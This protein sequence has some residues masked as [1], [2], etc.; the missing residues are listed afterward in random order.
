VLSGRVPFVGLITLPEK[1]YRVWCV[2]VLSS[3]LDNEE[4]LAMKKALFMI[5]T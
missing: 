1:S 4:A 2:R 5:Y 3:N